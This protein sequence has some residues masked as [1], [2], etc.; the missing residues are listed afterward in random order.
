M[1]DKSLLAGNYIVFAC[2][3]KISKH[4]ISL[5]FASTEQDFIRTKLPSVLIKCPLRE[6]SVF[7][8]G[9]FNDVTGEFKKTVKKSIKLDS[10]YFPHS[11]LS[12]PGEDLKLEDIDE[13]IQ[14]TKNEILANSS[15]NK[16]DENIK[17]GEE[18]E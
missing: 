4:Y 7:K 1:R 5:E 13:S 17:E 2:F 18:N 6:L 10:Y 15:D 16:S 3:D 11:R 8:I 12:P 14:K 9:I